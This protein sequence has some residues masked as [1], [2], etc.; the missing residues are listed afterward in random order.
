[1]FSTRSDAIKPTFKKIN[2]AA[3]Y[4]S[5]ELRSKERWDQTPEEAPGSESLPGPGQKLAG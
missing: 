4:W 1:M 5:Q 3:V 2:L